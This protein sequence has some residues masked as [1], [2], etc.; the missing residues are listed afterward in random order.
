[1]GPLSEFSSTILI[2]KDF[3]HGVC[4]RVWVSWGDWQSG[5]RVP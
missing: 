2:L 5:S 3:D 4:E 1:M